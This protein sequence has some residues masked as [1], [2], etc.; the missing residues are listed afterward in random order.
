MN[1]RTQ[2]TLE[3]SPDALPPPDELATITDRVF[4]DM[5]YGIDRPAQCVL[6]IVS[7]TDDDDGPSVHVTGDKTRPV[8][9]CR[10]SATTDW[11]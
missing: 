9:W 6:S 3:W 11:S 7:L 8:F 1:L 5:E 2:T 10:Y 4:A